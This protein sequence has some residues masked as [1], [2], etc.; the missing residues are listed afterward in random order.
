MAGLEEQVSLDIA[1]ALQDADDLAQRV[2]DSLE[3]AIATALEGL[4][5]QFAGIASDLGDQLTAAATDV[6][7]TADASAIPDEITGA[8]EGLA[9]VI[10]VDADTA[11]AT[12][13]LDDLVARADAEQ[14]TISVE[15]D[16]S[17]AEAAIDEVAASAE[18][19]SASLQAGG[20]AAGGFADSTGLL[21]GAAAL[22]VGKVGGL[23]EAAKGLSTGTAAAVAGVT[24]LGVGAFELFQKGVDATSALQRFNLIVGDM[25]EQVLHVN[26]GTLNEQLDDLAIKLGTDDEALRDASASVFQFGVNSGASREQSAKFT[27]QVDALAARAVALKPSLGDVATVAEGMIRAFASGRDRALVPF[28]I[29][30]DKTA[31]S[32]RALAIAQADG[33]EEVTRFDNA[34][35]VAQLSVEKY[36]TTLGTTVAEGAKNAVIQQRSLKEQLDNVLEA[37]GKPLVAPLLDLF[38]ESLPAVEALGGALSNLAVSAIPVVKSGLEAAIPLLQTLSGALDIVTTATGEVGVTSTVT[39]AAIGAAFGAKGGLAG[40]GIG[41][42]V[43]GLG[44][45]ISDLGGFADA[46]KEAADNARILLREINNLSGARLVRSFEGAATIRALADDVSIATGRLR[47]FKD[48]A[49]TDATAARKLLDALEASGEPG[50]RYERVLLNINKAHADSAAAADKN[51]AAQENL[52]TQLPRLGEAYK[53]PIAAAEKFVT[54]LQKQ[55]E[56]ENRLINAQLGLTG[57]AINYERA[58]RDQTKAQED[59]NEALA[60][61]DP[62][63]IAEAELRKRDADLRLTQSTIALDK[64]QTDLNVDLKDPSAINSAIAHLQDLQR[65][66]PAAAS[67][68]EPYLAKLREQRDLLDF[69]AHLPP[70]VSYVDIVVTG[71]V[72]LQQVIDNLNQ[73]PESQR[74]AIALGYAAAEGMIVA[75]HPGGTLVKV[76]E[77]GHAEVIV[78]TDDPARAADLLRQSG[79]LQKL[80]QPTVYAP[81][82]A[83]APA[84]TT[85]AGPIDQSIHIGSIDASGQTDPTRTGI[86]VGRRFRVEQGLRT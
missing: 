60:S 51:R 73:I 71:D 56:I 12:G 54:A 18:S 74:V 82:Y 13:Q 15:A 84:G 80:P 43:G 62:D 85:A 19:A 9:P 24:A 16:T 5:T 53:D 44:G 27:N 4:S 17:G 58:V 81:S 66:Y 86:L 11:P 25:G 72:K 76:A 59:Y 21:S 6:P 37:A 30:L 79:L 75:P 69:L 78:P 64:A 52:T 10:P 67:T 40:A 65:Q 38:K 77:A 31:I 23:G 68:L 49:E 42:A 2:G 28:Q 61:G 34:T 45:L 1:S 63:K 14:A 48:V 35:A 7:I 83:T 26:V 8:V 33:R 22:A 57:A 3:S 50:A 32:A 29:V 47:T 41:A 55:E 39:G 36:G 20:E 70:V 46:E